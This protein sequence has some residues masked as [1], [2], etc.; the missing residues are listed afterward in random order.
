MSKTVFTYY[1]PIPTW[2]HREIVNIWKHNWNKAGFRPIVMNRRV[3]KR[4]PMFGN[5]LTRI[6]TFP[7]VNDPRYEEACYIRWL[8]FEVM[9]DICPDGRGTMSDYDVFNNGFDER[10]M[11]REDIVL[12]ELTRVPCLVTANKAGARRIV[13]FI[14]SRE[15]D[16][17]TGHYS[18]MYAFKESDWPITGHCL[19]FGEKRGEIPWRKAPTIHAASGAIQREAPGYDKTKYI[20]DHYG[21]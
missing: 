1:D 17:S 5:F 4:H 11:G 10:H 14:M 8:A 19:E 21:T 7:T 18:D 15:P 13:E 12:H 2:N 3:A 9:L 16:H 20:R 6:R